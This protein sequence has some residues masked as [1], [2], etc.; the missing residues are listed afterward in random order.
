MCHYS[1]CRLCST[2]RGFQGEQES[3][4]EF[5]ADDSTL[6][7]SGSAINSNGRVLL[8]RQRKLSEVHKMTFVL[9][10]RLGRCVRSSIAGRTFNLSALLTVLLLSSGCA[11]T[12]TLSQPAHERKPL[13]MSGARLDLASLRNEA[14]VTERFGVSAN[15]S[16][17]GSA[18]QCG[19]RFS[20]TRI[21][22]A[23]RDIL[24]ASIT[25]E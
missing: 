17:T 2:S 6:R 13:V 8:K 18:F 3:Q 24:Q 23:G 9:Q 20:C 12:S 5:D 7:L 1:P 19:I 16:V 15:I 21:Y 14:A 4:A 25:S 22:S 10:F 11:T